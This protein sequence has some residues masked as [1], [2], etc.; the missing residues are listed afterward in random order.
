MAYSLTWL[1]DVLEQAGLKVAEVP[2]WKDRGVR[3]MGAVRGV[4]CHHTAGPKRGNMPSLDVLVHGRP[5]LHGPLCQLGLG[6]DGTF[7]VVA[8]GCAQHAGPGA[9][10]GVTTGNSSFIGIE[11]ENAGTADDPWP[12]EQMEAYR[13][14]VAAILAKIGAGAEMCCGHKEYALPKGRKDDPSFGMDDF[15]AGV[16]AILSGAA[17]PK[18]LI[19]HIDEGGRRTLRRGMSGD[20]V[21]ALQAKLGVDADGAFGGATEAAVRSLQREHGLVPDGIV[22]PKSWAV[23]AGN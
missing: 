15:R 21:K 12:P 5:D 18:P 23:L 3:D 17:G 2:G 19:P 8:A 14:G 9:W 20:D 10:K 13:R 22:G 11:A 4:I 16:A 6:R 7:Y 1:P